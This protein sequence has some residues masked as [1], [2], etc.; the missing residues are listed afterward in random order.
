[1]AVL[2]PPATLKSPVR[3]ALRG[4]PGSAYDKP[5]SKYDS[6]HFRLLFRVR[7]PHYNRRTKKQSQTGM[8]ESDR[9]A[10][11]EQPQVPRDHSLADSKRH[12]GRGPQKHSERNRGL[13]APAT[14]RD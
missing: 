13:H 9:L 6:K 7:K 4:R 5:F 12:Q 10:L 1:M 14:Q 8:P 3:A 11:M 2:A